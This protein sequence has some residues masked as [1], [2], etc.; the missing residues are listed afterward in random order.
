MNIAVRKSVLSGFPIYLF[1]FFSTI[2][3]PTPILSQDF[4]HTHIY[5]YIT[6]PVVLHPIFYLKMVHFRCVALVTTHPAHQ[7]N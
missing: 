5:I 4:I 2:F 7:F 3:P 6:I 1:F